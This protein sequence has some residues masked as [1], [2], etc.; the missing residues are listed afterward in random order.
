VKSTRNHRSCPWYLLPFCQIA[1]W[2]TY[3]A[4]ST[5][6]LTIKGARHEQA[7]DE[8]LYL[9]RGIAQRA[10]TLSFRLADHIEV[11][12]AQMKNRLLQVDLV[13]EV[14]DA[15]EPRRIRIQANNDREPLSRRR[16][17]RKPRPDSRDCAPDDVDKAGDAAN[18]AAEC[19]SHGP[20]SS[21]QR[22]CHSP[23]ARAFP[24]IEDRFDHGRQTRDFPSQENRL[25][26]CCFA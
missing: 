19:A 14:P 15:I 7:R 20:P 8:A 9:H 21:R 3:P 16:P 13:R 10:F 26:L 17:R 12:S 18:R 25:H 4:C 22:I 1:R 2:L 6:V 11:R 5:D 23:R 24:D